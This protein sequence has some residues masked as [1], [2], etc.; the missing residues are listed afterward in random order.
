MASDTQSQDLITPDPLEMVIHPE[1]MA[2]EP[3]DPLYL[4]IPDDKLVKI[5]DK[6]IRASRNFFKKP[7]YNLYERRKKNEMYVLGR[8]INSK[9]E[10]NE[11]KIY[12]SRFMDNALYEIE[13]TIKPIA[14]Q[15]MPDLIIG[16][17]NDSNEARKTAESL[18]KAIDTQVKSRENRIALGIAFKHLPVYFVG[19][20]KAEWNPEKGKFGDFGF[21]PI[22]PDYIDIDHTASSPNADDMEFISEICPTTVQMVVMMFP[23]KRKEFFD[24]LKKDGVMAQEIQGEDDFTDS[25]M[26]TPVQ[27][28][29]V[30]FKWYEKEKDK[31]VL[32]SID[33][34]QDEMLREPGSKWKVLRGVIWK[35]EK[36]I[37]D[38]IKNPNFDYVGEEKD[39]VYPD[40]SDE[41]SKREVNANERFLSAAMGIPLNSITETVYRNYFGSPR[42]PYYLMTYDQ[43]GKIAYDETSRVE[44][45]LR[46]QQNMDKNG[47]NL[48]E[49]M[50]NKGKH[51]FSKEAGLEA[52]DVEKMDMSDPTQDLIVDGDV[53]K[54]HAFIPPPEPLPQAFENLDRILRR[55]KD[56]AGVSAVGGQLQSEVATSNQIGRENNFTVLDD[57]V[58]NTINPASEWMAQWSMH[59]IKLRYTEPHMV[60]LLGQKGQDAFISLKS[61]MVSEGMIVKIKASGT[62]KLK[63]HNEAQQM[64]QDQAIDPINF[65]RDMGFDDYVERADMYVTWMMDKN[66]YYIKYVQGL[67]TTE[68]QAAALGQQPVPQPMGQPPMQ[69]LMPQGA[70]QGQPLPIGGPQGP[71]PMN[72]SAVPASPPMMPQA[73]PRSL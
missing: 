69:Q 34:V 26:A 5:I 40:P 15:Q 68:Q 20:I 35:Y 30:W 61:N 36:C 62:D 32:D 46:N 70:P 6:R 72:T 44:Q 67:E 21:R 29:Q 71:S 66:S 49:A 7:A 8:Q 24:E 12:E 3:T 41:N 47:K 1:E 59:F 23:K 60:Y 31:K 39:F 16:P 13:S 2:F 18:T 43:W 28:R 19:V 27:I 10:R 56:L 4:D 65:Y 50:Q 45:N 48:E 58:E 53:N 11:M 25:D 33:A 38:K 55:M 14:M 54:T 63:A 37:L 52:S 9:E 64:W 73:S 22:H 42:V 57:L 17:N 51:V